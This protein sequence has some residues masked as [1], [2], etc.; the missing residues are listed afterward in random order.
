MKIKTLRNLDSVSRRD[1]L[2]FLGLSSAAAAAILANPELV[3]AMVWNHDL[4]SLPPMGD[5]AVIAAPGIDSEI[6]IRYGDIIND[7]G[8]AFGF[9]NDFIAFFPLVRGRLVPQNSTQALAANEALL[10]VNHETPIG[11]LMHGNP[12]P[13]LGGKPKTMAQVREEQLAVGGSVIRIVRDSIKSQ[14]RF[15]GRHALNRRIT[16][17]TQI[18]F[19][20]TGSKKVSI[21]GSDHATGTLANCAGGVTPWGTVLSCEENYHEFY[22]EFEREYDHR[23]SNWGKH[24]KIPAQNHDWHVHAVHHPFHYGWVVEIDPLTGKSHKLVAMGRAARECA[25]VTTARDGRAVVYSG[26]DHRGGCI[27]KFIS[28]KPGDLTDGDLYAADV[29]RGRWILLSWDKNPVLRKS[30][31]DQ[32]DVLLHAR[33][34]G[35]GAGATAMDRPEDVE[36]HPLTGSVYISLTNNQDRGNYHGSLLKLEESNSD[37]LALDFRATTFLTG[38]KE[39]GF[40]SPDNLLFDRAGNLLFTTDVA[41]DKLHKGPY[42]GLGNNG[43]FVVPVKGHDAGKVLRIASAPVEAEFTGPCFSPDEKTLFL[44]VQHP[45]EATPFENG[46]PRYSSS[47]PDGVR[48]GKP[49][50]ALIALQNLPLVGARPQS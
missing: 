35:L 37:P 10:W 46:A 15:G 25:T 28:K 49:C 44:S 31:H 41:K 20:G 3:S 48:G 38:G 21:G 13:A 7:A 5:D 9:N 50:P 24:V 29:E 1:F 4:Q 42:S 14:W 22:G 47:W 43:L 45:G 32:M 19:A 40:S 8:E 18:P 39:T 26:D 27:F 16:A 2:A 33:A 23:D 6:L 17:L 12:G 11:G 30:F 34:A 36:L